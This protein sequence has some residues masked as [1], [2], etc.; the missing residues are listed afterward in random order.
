MQP[1]LEPSYVHRLGTLGALPDLE[2]G[3]LTFNQR[4]AS[5]WRAVTSTLPIG[6]VT[7]GDRREH[8]YASSAVVH[9]ATLTEEAPDHQFWVAAGGHVTGTPHTQRN[10]PSSD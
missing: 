2:L 3:P 7:V 8:Q 4:P 10:R 1:P 6:G 9:A 5:S